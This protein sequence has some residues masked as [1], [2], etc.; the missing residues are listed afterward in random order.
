MRKLYVFSEDSSIAVIVKF[1]EQNSFTKVEDVVQDYVHHAAKKESS[2]RQPYRPSSIVNS[3][4][5]LPSF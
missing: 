1:T 5:Q 2:E 3:C 4:S